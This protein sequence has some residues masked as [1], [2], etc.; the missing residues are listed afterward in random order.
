MEEVE[1]AAVMLL[2]EGN[3]DED[4]MYADDNAEVRPVKTLLSFVF[5]YCFCIRRRTND[6][7]FTFTLP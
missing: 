5:C 6:F 4:L 7:Y 2:D 3:S 1:E